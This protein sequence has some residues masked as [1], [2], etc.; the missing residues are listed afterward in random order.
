MINSADGSKALSGAIGADRLVLGFPGAGGSRLDDGTVLYRVVT[1]AIQRT[2]FGELRGAV[3]D[4]VRAVGHA[5]STAGFPV[6]LTGRMEAWQKTHVAMVSPLANGF[7]A[8][9]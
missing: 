6:A 8:K 7:Y 3:S 2:T 1:K 4:Q 9:A 5:I